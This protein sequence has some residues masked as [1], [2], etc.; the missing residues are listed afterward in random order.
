MVSFT[1]DSTGTPE[2][3]WRDAGLDA[4]KDLDPRAIPGK[5]GHVVVVS[6]HPDD[7]ALAA[8]GLIQ[9]AIT[10]GAHVTVL[11]CTAGEA[12]HPNSPTHSPQQ[13][14]DLRLQE[15]HR[16]LAHLGREEQL[17]LDYLK[18]HDGA[19]VASG[20]ALDA[21]LLRAIRSTNRPTVLAV[22][23]AADGHTDH[24]AVGVSGRRV[25][26]LAGV[27]LLEFPIWYWHWAPPSDPRWRDFERLE[28][29][30]QEVAGKRAALAEHVSQIQPLSEQPGDEVLLTE[31]VRAHF[32]RDFELFRFTPVVELG[33]TSAQ[34]VFD[35]L[36]RR[37][38][39]PW[40]YV[41]SWYERRKRAVTGA[42]LPRERYERAVEAGC[43]I[44]VLTQDL[45][46][47]CSS[48][49]G[50]DASSE[51]L[52]LARARLSGLNTV[53]LRLAQLPRDWD[54]RPASLDLV[55]VS[56]IGYFL[57]E[58]ELTQLLTAAWNSL[59][60][61]GHLLLCHWL[62]PIDG[63]PLDGHRVHELARTITQEPPVIH[64]RESAFLLEVF[65]KKE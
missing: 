46:D 19:V 51:A 23:Y 27:P 29:T 15:M 20:S 57:T 44:G 45:A 55:V 21:A 41:D 33:S 63:W 24:E 9:R 5:D 42:S 48:V 62:G 32:E 2:S 28:L 12:S 50:L 8:A 6:A 34:E 14:A 54:F 26:A 58:D 56:E 4:L 49:V 25:A 18:M 36:Y 1:H 53:E 16:A 59:S 60:P 17:T 43:S 65:E 64:H 10:G 38:K 61:H 40:A 11:L 52:E 3:A 22:T 13:L 35:D 30:A 37:D 47:R 39:D 7:E 31:S